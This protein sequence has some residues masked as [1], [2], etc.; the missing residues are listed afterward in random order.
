MVTTEDTVTLTVEKVDGS[1]LTTVVTATPLQYEGPITVGQ[2]PPFMAAIAGQNYLN[3]PQNL[4]FTS[5]R[6]SAVLSTVIHSTLTLYCMNVHDSFASSI[7]TQLSFSLA[8][9]VSTLSSPLAF[10]IQLSVTPTQTK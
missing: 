2:L 9:N 10:G 5:G 6:V 7:Q 4:E 3:E 1:D 8:T